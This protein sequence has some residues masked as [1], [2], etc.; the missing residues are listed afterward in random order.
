MTEQRSTIATCK[1]RE[2]M[3]GGQVESVALN[4]GVKYR[5]LIPQT[6]EENNLFAVPSKL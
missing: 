2:R 4:F 1:Y 6:A 3:N 5:E